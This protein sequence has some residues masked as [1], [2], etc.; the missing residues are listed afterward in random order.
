MARPGIALPEPAVLPEHELL[1]RIFR[2]L[3]EAT[4]LRILEHLLEH[5]SVRQ[6]ELVEKLGTTQSRMSEH[7]SV[8]IWCGFIQA[9]RVGRSVGYEIADPIVDEFVGLA[10]SFLY[11]NPNAVG[12]CRTEEGDSKRTAQVYGVL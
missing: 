4:R 12:G 3:G 1:A 6:I 8:L 11:G 7:V 2:T 10:R 5:G 9:H